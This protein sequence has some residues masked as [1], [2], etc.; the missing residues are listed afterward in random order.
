[1]IQIRR[2]E[3][4][5]T[6]LK[7]K[8]DEGRSKGVLIYTN[9]TKEEVIKLCKKPQAFGEFR[10]AIDFKNKIFYAWSADVKNSDVLEGLGMSK[11][12]PIGD[13]QY[14]LYDDGKLNATLSLVKNLKKEEKDWLKKQTP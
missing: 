2:F 11:D 9:P 5:Y 3:G 14:N 4:F 7:I 10:F 6:S 13:G 1:M 8:D 12:S